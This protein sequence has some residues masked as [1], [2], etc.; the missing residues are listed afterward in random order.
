MTYPGYVKTAESSHEL[1]H[2]AS[3]ALS[4]KTTNYPGAKEKALPEF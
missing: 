1:P 3:G 2:S 4:L